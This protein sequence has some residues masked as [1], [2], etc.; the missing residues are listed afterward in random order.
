MRGRCLV[1]ASRTG[2]AKPEAE[3]HV[4]ALQAR[5]VDVQIV[6]ADV[7]KP[8]DVARLMAE[9]HAMGH[10]LR[11][12]FHLAMVIDDA[13]LAALNSDR[14]RA[15]MEPKAYGAWLLHEATRDMRLDCFAMFSSVSSIFGNP[16]QGITAPRMRFLILWRIIGGHSDFRP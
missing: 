4:L 1:L 11:G 9:I 5:G 16:A 10:S 14:M 3:A 7:G 6:K 2:A 8:A 12:V 13:P 15:V